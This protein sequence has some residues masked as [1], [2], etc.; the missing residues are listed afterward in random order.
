[1]VQTLF[2]IKVIKPGILIRDRFGNIL[3]ARSTVTLVRNDDLNLIVDTGLSSER[4]SIL[5]ALNELQLNPDNIDF[6]I[7]THSHADHTGNNTIFSEATFI[8]HRDE[9][10]VQN[11]KLNCIFISK[12][13]HT[14]PGITAIETPGHTHGS[15]S[16]LLSGQML[17]F[18]GTFAIT[19]DAIPIL[20]NF[21][22]WVP[23]GINYSTNIAL[24]SMKNIIDKADY[25]IPGHDKPFR[26]INNEKRIAEYLY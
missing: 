9:F 22:K 24:N 20:D 12:E 16:L 8:I 6:V 18:Q 15:I 5:K 19:G 2:D 21:L 17:D 1:M 14:I 13:D 23:P 4:N 11:G 26:I 7:N 3:D 25:I 10:S